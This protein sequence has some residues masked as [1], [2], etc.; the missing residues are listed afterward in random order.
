LQL[1]YLLRAQG[2]PAEDIFIWLSTKKGITV[3]EPCS[4][5]L[6]PRLCAPYGYEKSIGR[7]Y[8][9]DVTFRFAAFLERADL[10]AIVWVGLNHGDTTALRFR[11]QGNIMWLFS[12]ILLDY[13]SKMTKDVLTSGIIVSNDDSLVNTLKDPVSGSSVRYSIQSSMMM[14]ELMELIAYTD[15]NPLLTDLAG[16]LNGL[17]GGGF[18]AEC[19]QNDKS[20]AGVRL[21]DFFGGRVKPDEISLCWGR[22][23]AIP[24]YSGPEAS[25]RIF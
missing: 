5:L 17:G 13:R 23:K 24:F 12:S 22:K 1:S 2:V 6:G 16:R 20:T 19:H 11:E 3:A 14:R 9:S 8:E 10:D 7:R 4:C 21:R 18:R 15:E 25:R